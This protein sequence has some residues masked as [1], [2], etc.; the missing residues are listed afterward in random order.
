[1][2]YQWNWS[3]FLEASP[4]GTQTYAG[5]LMSGLAW[6]VLTALVA[7]AIAFVLGSAIGVARSLPRRPILASAAA[8]YVE[9]FRN[10]PLLLQLFLWYFVLPELLPEP[11][12]GWVKHLPYGSFWT[13]ALG[14]GLYMASRLAEQ[15]RAGLAA[16]GAGQ[17]AAARALGL[18]TAQIY[19][20]VAMPQAYRIILPTLT[21]EF[22]NTIKNSSVGLGI[23]LLELTARAQSIQEY[24][25][26]VFEAFAAATILY[27]LLNALVTAA[28]RAL[29]KRIAIPGMEAVLR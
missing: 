15:V 10:V 21:S 6:T 18:G 16:V 24:S 2:R 3:V 29:E 22:L 7:W 4:E 17:F 26:Q 8:A 19:W 14:L 11:L 12:A 9:L 23:G 28:G 20:R 5:L 1:M 25:S 27:L 13:T